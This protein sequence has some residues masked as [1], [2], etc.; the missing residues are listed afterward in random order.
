M[1]RIIG[2]LDM[3]AFFASVEERDKPYLKGAPVIVGADPHTGIGRGVVSTANYRARELGIHSALPIRR[4][5]ELCSGV[6]PACV[7]IT[8]TFKR[9]GP[10]AR[11]VFALVRECVS[12]VEQTSIDEAYLDMSH[13]RS[14][15][16]ARTVARELQKRIQ[17]HTKLTCSIGIGPTKMVAKIASDFNKPNGLTVVSDARVEDFLASLPIETLPG[18][19]THMVRTLHRRGLRTI[20]DVQQRSWQELQRLLGSRGLSLWEKA[21]GIDART[22]SDIEAPRKSIGKHHTFAHDT[23]AMEEVF[24]VMRGQVVDVQRT[25]MRKG[26][27]G[28]R[29]V[30]VTVR[31]DNFTTKTRS[32]TFDAP[33]TRAHDIELAATKLLLPFFERSENPE[34]RALRLVGIRIEK[35]V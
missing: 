34:K 3:D 17:A 30:V 8:P 28:C 13:C 32:L 15:T 10:V 7:F 33:R 29:T 21:R 9:Y 24:A 14:F 27:R 23:A 6:T 22:V 25:L 31:F 19:G 5:V 11:E 35:L 18:V 1:K 2:H 26:F 12:T 20:A 4:A 16:D